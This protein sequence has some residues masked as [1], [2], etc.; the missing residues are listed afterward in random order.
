MKGVVKRIV[1]EGSLPGVLLIIILLLI[2]VID[3]VLRL[4]DK[5]KIHF[6]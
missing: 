1:K 2:K 6:R 3:S 4:F 5:I